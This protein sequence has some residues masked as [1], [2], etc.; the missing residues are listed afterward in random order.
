MASLQDFQ[1]LV[2]QTARIVASPKASART[3]NRIRE[4]GASD[5]G[6]NV[7][8]VLSA[9]PLFNGGAAVLLTSTSTEWFGWLP[10]EEIEL[11]P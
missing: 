10:V 7:N 6:F 2:G 8:K 5:A 11:V 4:N 3:K 1:P 9:S